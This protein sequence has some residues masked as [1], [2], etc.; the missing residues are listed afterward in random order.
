MIRLLIV[1]L[2]LGVLGGCSVMD[3]VRK[4]FYMTDEEKQAEK[5]AR[6]AEHRSKC[7]ELG[8]DPEY[9][10]HTNCVLRLEQSWIEAEAVKDAADSIWIHS[11]S[12]PQSQ[13]IRHCAPDYVTGGCL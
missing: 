11:S 2:I 13:P 5:E 7:T 12:Q 9:V 10:E 1:C 8:F 3:G 6:F 4:N